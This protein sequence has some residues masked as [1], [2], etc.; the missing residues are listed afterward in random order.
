MKF[1][2]LLIGGLQKR[3][4]LYFL[5]TRQNDRRRQSTLNMTVQTTYYVI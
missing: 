3:A 5:Y 1:V 2:G 4:G